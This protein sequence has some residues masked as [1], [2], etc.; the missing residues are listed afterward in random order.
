VTFAGSSV[1]NPGQPVSESCGPS[2]EVADHTNNLWR[3]RKSR[4]TWIDGG[5]VAA[6]DP[7]PLP[8]R[9]KAQKAE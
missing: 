1:G 4:R 9:G 6:G 5:L 3:E 7:F 8:Y 2:C